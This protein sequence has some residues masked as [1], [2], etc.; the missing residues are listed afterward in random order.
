MHTGSSTTKR[1]LLAVFWF[2]AAYAALYPWIERTSPEPGTSKQKLAPG[3][4]DFAAIS[5]VQTKKQAF[6]SYLL[7]EIHR[8]NE[9]VLAERH[10]VMGMQDKLARGETLSPA[11]QQRVDTLAKKYKIKEDNS[12]SE[13]LTVLLRRA[14]IIPPELVLAQ[15]ANESAW[16]TSRFARRGYNFFGLWCFKRG[17]GFVPKQR[18]DG[19]AHE[20]AKFRDLSHATMTYIRNL[21]RHYAYKELR[22]I[23]ASLRQNQ[24]DITAEALVQGLSRYSERGQAYIDELLQM[25]R[26]NRKYMQV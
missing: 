15:A 22:D 10:F 7:P 8:Q 12:L 9:Q 14:D 2:M 24:Q 5:D 1:V 18:N 26:Y 25:I 20:V 19:A 11:Q 6:F 17:C 4:P 16:G 21:N 3:I 23:R 13:T